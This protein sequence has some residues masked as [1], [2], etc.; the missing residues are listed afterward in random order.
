M[1]D[2]HLHSNYSD[3]FDTPNQLIDKGIKLNLRAIALTDHDTIEGNKEFISYGE[4][5]NIIVL[6]GVEI[7]I[8]H[9]FK[10]EIKDVHVIG[11]NIDCESIN[12]KNVLNKQME[13]RLKQKEEI[14]NRLRD[15]YDYNISYE[16]VR[17]IA[18]NKTV[19]RPHIVDIMMKNNPDK[20]KG[21]TK[22]DLF[23][24][25]SIDG[26]A[27]VDRE[28]ELTL[29]ETIE[30]I[31]GAGGISILAHPGVYEVSNRA[32]FVEF[33]ANS[34]IKG[35]EIEYIY[36][37]NRPFDN[38]ANTEKS[39]WA[40]NYFPRFY[41]NLAEKFKLIKSGG[42]DYHGDKKNINI[43]EAC[44]PDGYLKYFI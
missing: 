14:C 7:S 42:S 5:K 20:I 15:E 16:E 18:G 9:D 13:G 3:G 21:K 28:F 26:V 37:K 6:P 4:D 36:A 40:Q 25:I 30:V 19:G 17:A 44:V 27:Y 2:L 41:K 22:N 39:Q 12:L 1:I 38:N 24:M 10:R 32:K 33:C 23:K 31:N 11:L 43:G 8:K 29:E 35:I 34:G